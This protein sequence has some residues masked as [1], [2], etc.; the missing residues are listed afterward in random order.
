MAMAFFLMDDKKAKDPKSEL[1]PYYNVL[2]WNSHLSF[3]MMF[4][5]K[6]HEWLQGS[7]VS[8]MAKA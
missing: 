2:P 8:K 7:P 3:P 6:E 4:N 1:S 5:F